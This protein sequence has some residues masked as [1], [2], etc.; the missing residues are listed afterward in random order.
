MH[1]GTKL[2]VIVAATAALVVPAATAASAAP[3]SAPETCGCGN[4]SPL[5]VGTDSAGN[6]YVFYNGGDGSLWEKWSNAS[7][8][9]WYGPS[10]I[11]GTSAG[12]GANLAVAVHPNGEQDVFWENMNNS[13]LDELSF[14]PGKGWGKSPTD[15]GRDVGDDNT[16]WTSLSAGSDRYGNDYVVYEGNGDAS[17]WEKTHINGVWS[18]PLKVY[19]PNPA[20]FLGEA[21]PSAVNT[22]PAIAVQPSGRQDVFWM[23][24][25]STTFTANI[26]ED[27]TGSTGKFSATAKNLGIT[28]TQPTDDVWVA[29]GG[30][31][32]NDYLFWQDPN[33]GLRWVWYS[34]GTLKW[35]GGATGQQ[36]LDANTYGGLSQGPSVVVHS[37][38]SIDVFWYAQNVSA[39][40]TVSID[41][42]EL[43]YR[44]GAWQTSPVNHGPF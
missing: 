35:Y 42:M 15:L 1:L 2:V 22:G 3:T 19:D 18:G 10:E 36:L 34:G 17:V 32:G 4:K 41:L 33:G 40:G 38:S 12:V 20:G 21:P 31:L 27:S 6:D 29:A 23:G 8:T 26:W 14:V 43:S 44:N 7:G 30:I 28:T 16:F 37:T 39:S 24:Y 11:L 13:E 5:A 9:V 25:N